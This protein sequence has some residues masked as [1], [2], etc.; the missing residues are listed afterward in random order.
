MS[1]HFQI[2]RKDL[3]QTRVATTA[4]ARLLPGQVRLHV[5]AFSLTSNNI[6]YGAFGDAMHYWDFFPTGDG[7]WG[8]LP[9][10]GFA[11]VVESQVEGVAAGERFYGYY[12]MSDELV[13]QP[14]RIGL[15]SFDDGSEHR[16]SLPAVYNQYTRCS[17]DRAYRADAEAQIAIY[18]PLFI[19]SFLI[20]D[21]LDETGFFGARSV[22]LSSASS[23]TA[24]GTAFCLSQ[25]RGRPNAVKVI[26][27]TSPANLAFTQSLGCYDELHVYDEIEKLDA[28]T[29]TVFVDFAGDAA[30]R[31]RLHEQLR[32][33]LA[34]SCSV[35]GTHVDALGSGKGLPGPKPV[36]FFAP[37]RIKKRLADWT[38]T[39][40]QRRIAESW[41]AFMQ[42]VMQAQP[43][44]L[45][46]MRGQGPAAVEAAYRR[47]LDGTMDPREGYFLSL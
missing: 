5:D 36:L 45:R 18:R 20:D 19:T 47:L 35:G 28:Q 6:T 7:D 41:L 30:L 29:A 40:L 4:A 37:D 34:Y 13:V 10:W 3:R 8:S 42:P 16:R 43:P 17:A 24:Y 2:A 9:V 31:A 14:A 38:P 25:R 33:T 26:G 21:F 44:W 12:P 27:L 46:V 23:K 32:E 1:S 39:G 22:V 11:D 15:A